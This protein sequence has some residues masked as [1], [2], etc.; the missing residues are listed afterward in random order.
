M[1]TF[2]H[3][4]DG[5]NECVKKWCTKEKVDT[6]VLSEWRCRLLYEI[7]VK[8]HSLKHRHFEV[9]K[10]VLDDNKVN[11]FLHD[12]HKKFVITPTDK[13]SNNFSIVCKQFYISCLMKELNILESNSK[14]QSQSTYERMKTKPNDIVKRHVKYMKEHNIDLAE[15]Q[16]RLPFIYWIP[17]MHK[18]PSKQR[19][20]AASHSCS[21]KPLSKMITFCL[22][23]IQQTH[24]NYCKA[25]AK[26]NSFN[27]M[28]IVDN[29]VEVIDKINEIN[30]KEQVKNIRT[31]DFST[32]YTSIPHKKLK[33]LIWVI[34]E[35]F[36]NESRKFIRIGKDSACWS[37]S[38]G[39]T[40]NCW[41]KDELIKHVRWLIDNIYVVCGDSL[42]KQK[43]G[44]P[45]GTDCAPFLAN[46]FLFAYECK[47]LLKQFESK[48]FDVLNKFNYCFR[49]IDDLLCINNNQLMDN[50]TSEIY[51]EE[52]SL[53]SDDAVLQTHYLDLDLEIRNNKIHSKLF[54]K[55][56]AFGFSIVNF[57]N[58]S[59][60]I[61]KKQSYGVFVSQMIRYAR[62]CMDIE[63]FTFRTKKL[64]TRLTNQNF[65][66]KKLRQTFES[67]SISNYK[68]LFKYN[69]SINDICDYCF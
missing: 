8:I 56:D 24:T 25:I 45:M 18:S 54:D 57:P 37:K 49:Y 27:R 59:G 63:D 13:A 4:K 35:A 40:K 58:L 10:K 1:K 51:P 67:F 29:S 65:N 55:R 32:L 69:R 15:S 48:N 33:Q 19:Y 11:E 7:R 38:R 31:Y 36:N 64:V 43:I 12:F 21:T 6:V 60:N 5:V 14:K 52:L 34:S 2:H 20:I 53:T 46:L 62:C 17:K 9:P 42:F 3:I 61:P 28:W 44:I 26:N 68:L 16:L 30:S 23:L 22:K 47:W 66:I 39:K 50:V 41:D